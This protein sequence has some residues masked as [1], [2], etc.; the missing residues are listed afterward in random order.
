MIR[1]DSVG[2]FLVRAVELH[3]LLSGGLFEGFYDFDLDQ[4]G[5]SADAATDLEAYLLLIAGSPVLRGTDNAFYGNSIQGMRAQQAQCRTH[6][7]TYYFSHVTEQTFRGPLTGEYYPEP[8]MNPL[9]VATARY[10]GHARFD[11]QFYPGFRSSD[12]WPNDGVV[13]AFSQ[14]YPRIAGAHADGGPIDDQSGFDPGRW[15]QETENSVDHLDIVLSPEP[16]L[17]GYQKRF[18]VRLFE[19]LA[20]L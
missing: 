9:L 2:D 1:E 12:W 17:I 19:R 5:V 16:G 15:Y 7:E 10:I 6:P 11:H 8:G 3:I 18:Y 4:W 20:S 14:A 13:P